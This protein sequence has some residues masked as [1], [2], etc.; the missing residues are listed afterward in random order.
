[1]VIIISQYWSI[2]NQHVAYFKLKN[3]YMP[4]I[5]QYIWKKEVKLSLWVDNVIIV[6]KKFKRMQLSEL[7]SELIKVFGY[8]VNIE[9]PIVFKYTSNKQLESKVNHL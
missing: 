6:I 9:K 5:S 2:S 7:V 3:F 8:C 1:M 4:I